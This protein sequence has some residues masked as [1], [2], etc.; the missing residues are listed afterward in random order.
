MTNVER[1]G[2]P[3][4]ARPNW[5]SVRHTSNKSLRETQ[6]EFILGFS[7]LNLILTL[8]TDTKELEKIKEK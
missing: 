5:F 2:G 7:T 8:K 6:L 4:S 3:A 1:D